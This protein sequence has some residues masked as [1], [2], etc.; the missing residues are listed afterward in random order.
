MYT[1]LHWSRVLN[2]RPEMPPRLGPVTGFYRDSH[3]WIDSVI[4]K[5][6]MCMEAILSGLRDVTPK[7]NFQFF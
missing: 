2:P 4:V 6:N 7:V 1:K 3:P 5:L